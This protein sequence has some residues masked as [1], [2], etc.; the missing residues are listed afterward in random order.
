MKPKPKRKSY[1][2]PTFDPYHIK[3]RYF[4]TGTISQLPGW[5]EA[6]KSSGIY[7]VTVTCENTGETFM[8]EAA[9][10]LSTAA[11]IPMP[12]PN[13]QGQYTAYKVARFK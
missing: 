3:T 8:A 10:I 12:T 1:R 5:F 11:F 7:L 9:L 13:T 6:L 2:T 4:A